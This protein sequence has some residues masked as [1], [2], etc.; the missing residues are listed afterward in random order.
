MRPRL[1]FSYFCRSRLRKRKIS[2]KKP[3]QTA[4]AKRRYTSV[5]LALIVSAAT[6]TPME[7]MAGKRRWSSKTGQIA[8]WMHNSLGQ[9]TQKTRTRRS[10]GAAVAAG[11]LPFQQREGQFWAFTLSS[12]T[13]L[14][15]YQGAATTQ[16]FRKV[17]NQLWWIPKITIQEVPEW[18]AYVKIRPMSINV[19]IVH[20][21]PCFYHV[22]H[23]ILNSSVVPLSAATHAE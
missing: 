18:Q 16:A 10:S 22:R 20:K 1:S 23:I 3:E 4:R 13:S 5:T 19:K 2:G 7:H 8:C 11:F 14:D 6:S 21:R 12:S 17:W 9:D 15:L